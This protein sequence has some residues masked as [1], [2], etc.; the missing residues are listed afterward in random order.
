M[1]LVILARLGYVLAVLVAV[2]FITFCL[3]R[4]I[5]GDPAAMIAGPRATT[6]EIAAIQ[7][8][9]GLNR[10][11][12]AQY[13]LYLRDLMRGDLGSS[14]VTGRPVLDDLRTYAPAT[15]ELMGIAFILSTMLGVVGGVA[16][17]ATNRSWIDRT[18]RGVVIL[19]ISVPPFIVGLGLLTVLY[20]TLGLL[21][22]A[23]RLSTGIEPPPHVT[24]LYIVDFLIAGRPIL[25]I[26]ALSHVALPAIT[27]ALMSMGKVLRLTRAA[28]LES[29]SQDYIRTARALGTSEIRTLIR[30]ALPNAALTIVTFLGLELGSLIFGSVIVESIFSWPGTGTY[31][32]NSI[33]NLDFPAIMAFATASSIVYCIVNLLIDLLYVVI[34]PRLRRS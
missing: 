11:W 27:L 16:A 33:M 32:L 24:G 14:I 4:M 26:D 6:Q 21:P 31:I 3:S 30:H 29:L 1:R 5:P 8:R 34:D 2:S 15:F 18:I 10:P 23:G 13:G 19:A 17:A 22:G 9:L 25:A 20:G 7:L 12:P 28:M